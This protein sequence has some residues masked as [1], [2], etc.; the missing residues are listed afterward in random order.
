MKSISNFDNHSDYWY[1]LPAILFIDLVVIIIGRYFPSVFGRYLNVWYNKFGLGAV[2]AD[3][4]I[5]AIGFMIARWIYTRFLAGKFGMNQALFIGLLVVVQLI[6]DLLFYVGVIVPI[7]RGAN[8]MMDV[9]KDYANQGGAK[10]LGADAGM[11]IGS[12]LVASL[13]KNSSGGF[14]EV[15]TISTIY[16]LPYFL[17]HK[18]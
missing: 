6:H 17:E 1:I 8:Q 4:F 2:I 7:P 12:A 9:F 15:F 11:M 5:I 3:V 18:V 13:L 16:L 14:Y 10:I